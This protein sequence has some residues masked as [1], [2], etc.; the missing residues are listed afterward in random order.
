MILK[1]KKEIESARMEADASAAA[2]HQARSKLKDAEK[3]LDTLR[4][5]LDEAEKEM[6]M[7]LP[8][9]PN[10]ENPNGVSQ[11]SGTQRHAHTFEKTLD[12]ATAPKRNRKYPETFV[13]SFDKLVSSHWQSMITQAGEHH[14]QQVPNDPSTLLTLRAV[15]EV[16]DKLVE[17]GTLKR[18]VQLDLDKKAGPKRYTRLV[19]PHPDPLHLVVLH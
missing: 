7:P 16:I 19:L 15:Y 10:P 14:K 17:E 18:G 12:A 9:D 6:G 2:M 1:L 13:G 4:K 8:H 5:K 3:K 11:N